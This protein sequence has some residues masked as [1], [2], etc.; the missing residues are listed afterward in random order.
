MQVQAP[1]PLR[2]TSRNNPPC[3]PLDEA[4]RAAARPCCRHRPGC[5]PPPARARVPW[6]LHLRSQRQRPW[7]RQTRHW[8]Q[9]WRR[10]S[11]LARGAGSRGAPVRTNAVALKLPHDMAQQ[12]EASCDSSKC[13]I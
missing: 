1:D 11:L 9:L 8:R 3:P 7:R 5:T 10:S 13:L 12:K 6:C 2:S 4:H